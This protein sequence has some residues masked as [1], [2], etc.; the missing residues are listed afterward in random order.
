M[1]ACWGLAQPP[2][3]TL[4]GLAGC[5]SVCLHLTLLQI[6]IFHIIIAASP[7]L[8]RSL[9]ELRLMMAAQDPRRWEGNV[10]CQSQHSLA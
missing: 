8:P 10:S 1:T 5:L 7:P 2:Q 4:Q 9:A 6:D 3:N